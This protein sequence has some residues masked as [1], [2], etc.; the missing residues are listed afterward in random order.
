V[1]LQRLLG[2]L[3]GGTL[4]ARPKRHHMA[5]SFLT[6]GPGTFPGASFLDASTIMTVAALGFGAYE[7]YRT[8]SGAGST[9]NAT[10][11]GS[12]AIPA[13]P[14]IANPPSRASSAPFS[15]PQVFGG[16][17]STVEVVPSEPTSTRV[18]PVPGVP[19][20]PAIPMPST[21]TLASAAEI[22]RGTGGSP[23]SELPAES[24]SDG[25]RRIAALLVAAARADGE[26]GEEEFAELVK[27]AQANGADREVQAALVNPRP[28]AEIVAGV[29]DPK[30]KEDL[31]VLAFTIVRADEDV[32]GAE[33]IWLAGLASALGLDPAST[34]RI[35]KDTIQRIHRT[36]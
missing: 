15:L 28:V 17:R 7:I 27:A 31:Y 33:R 29:R 23:S 19:P 13:A 14:S 25:V 26:L 20:L 1:N 4:S 2:S 16:A 11:G 5:S 8:R 6:G 10:L 21:P 18:P 9:S 34:A 3:I 22:A 35:E 32:S 30:L 12:P 24:A 36:P